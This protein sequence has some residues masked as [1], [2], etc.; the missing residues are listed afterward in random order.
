MRIQLLGLSDRD[1]YDLL[2][3][4]N[5]MAVLSLFVD[6]RNVRPFHLWP[7]NIG[8]LRRDLLGDFEIWL[9]YMSNCL[10]H[11]DFN[12]FVGHF[13]MWIWN[14]GELEVL[15]Q[16]RAGLEDMLKDMKRKVLKWSRIFIWADA[17]FKIIES[18]QFGTNNENL[19]DTGRYCSCPFQDNILPKLMTTSGSYEEL[20]KKEL[21]K[22]DPICI[23]VAKNV[24]AQ[25]RL[26]QQIK[27]PIFSDVLVSCAC[28]CGLLIVPFS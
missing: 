13:L 26:L 17:P 7:P 16:Q 1:W 20:F 9:L 25:E 19:V 28:S 2:G 23:E 4:L 14:Q 21:A 6:E 3:L 12:G 8:S 15:G 27:V 22:F 24:D 18:D 5:C 11:E 10:L